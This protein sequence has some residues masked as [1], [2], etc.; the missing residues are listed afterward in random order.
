VFDRARLVPGPGEHTTRPMTPDDLD[1]VRE[2]DRLAFESYRRQ[3]RQLLR[4]QRSRTLHNMRAALH[5]PHPGVVVEWREEVVGYCFTHVWGSLGWLGTLGVRPRL[6]GYGLGQAVIAAGLDILR[7]AGCRVL[8]LE[9]MPESGKNQAIYTRQGLEPRFM[10]LLCRGRLSP[11]AASTHFTVWNGGPELQTIA[12]QLVTGLDVTPA[13]RWLADEGA[14][15]TLVWWQDNAPV[16]LAVLRHQS[17]HRDSVQSYLTVEAMACL[18][19]VAGRWP[20]YLDEVNA[21]GARLDKTGL[22]LPVNGWQID[23]LRAVLDRHM[24]I[25]HTR[26]RMVN[27]PPLGKR[28][29]LLALT[30]A[31]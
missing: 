3:H 9:T 15:A 2:I 4:P 10:T 5:R 31:M 28:D 22:V 13:A 26:V 21:Y 20:R 12:E 30:L 11:P 8:A 25:A 27:G 1:A 29:A 19:A 17:R 14:G 6:Q 7:A 16:A 24:E 18:P 23:L